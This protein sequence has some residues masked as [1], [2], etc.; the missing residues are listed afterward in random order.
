MCLGRCISFIHTY[1]PHPHCK[2]N[3]AVVLNIVCTL[4]LFFHHG[5]RSFEPLMG[6]KTGRSFLSL[7]ELGNFRAP[8]LTYPNFIC[9]WSWN[10]G[11]VGFWQ[12]TMSGP[13]GTAYAGGVWKIYV[14]WK[15]R[16]VGTSNCVSSYRVR[17]WWNSICTYTQTRF[18]SLSC[19]KLYLHMYKA[20]D[21]LLY[22]Y[23][24]V[25]IYIYIYCACMYVM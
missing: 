24:Y 17:L 21:I 3:S 19:M 9:L 1:R 12:A 11:N 16:P 22:I 20:Q 13:D 7:I 23:L 5:M 18:R 6:S 25:Y 14:A 8:I 10:Q 15:A 4:Q 2:V